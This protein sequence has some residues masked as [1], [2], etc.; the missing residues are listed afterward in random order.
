MGAL[1]RLLLITD[2]FYLIAGGLLGPIYALYVA[3]IGGDLLDAANTY[4]IFMVTAGI[5][6]FLLGLWEDKA[7][8]QRKFVIAGYGLGVLGYAGYLLVANPL[9]LFIVQGILGL[10]VALK[11]PAY[12]A[13]FSRSG[14]K[15]LAFAWGEWE[16]VD[17][18]AL[19][20][21][22]FLG[23][24]IAHLHGFVTLLWFMAGL[25]MT[26]FVI[27]LL[28]LRLRERNL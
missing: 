18:I 8:H 10:S 28:L 22:A 14:G 27:S 17:Y 25:S 5:V 7:K 21:G 15:H 20:V 23:G 11:D 1:R 9:G 6:V 2:A 3:D 24:V 12:D 16:A 26:S 19:G 13:L 4:A